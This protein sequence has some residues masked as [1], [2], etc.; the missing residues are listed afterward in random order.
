MMR[1]S[2]SPCRGIDA[3]HTE[4]PLKTLASAIKTA[5]RQAG[6]IESQLGRFGP[7]ISTSGEG[8]SRDGGR[9]Q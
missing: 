3:D 8:S 4:G 7:V 1:S 2:P 6:Q 9:R 5:E